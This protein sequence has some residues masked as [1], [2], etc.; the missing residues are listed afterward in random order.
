MIK[1]NRI[2]SIMLI[3]G[4]SASLAAANT[5]SELTS[6]DCRSIFPGA[7][8]SE[9]TRTLESGVRWTEA[10][11]QGAWGPAEEF[12]GYVFL[13]TLPNE[14]KTIGVLVGMTKTGVIS[15]VS[16]R[17]LDGVDE[18]FLAQFRGK[19]PQDNFDLMRT[20][21]DLLV[22]PAKIRA[23]QGNFALSESIAQTVKEIVAS[24]NNVVK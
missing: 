5:P 18:A 14:G 3:V 2:I 11:E 20:P 12:L 13:K 23:M 8:S 7:N 16:V 9:K 10:W 4:L 21:E 24:A 22:V 1:P 15:K 6:T 17:G 19:T